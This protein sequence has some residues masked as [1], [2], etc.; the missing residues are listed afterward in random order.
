VAKGGI[1][2]QINIIW[3]SILILSC[4]VLG[5]LDE[6][7]ETYWDIPTIEGSGHISVEPFR[8]DNNLDIFNRATE[9]NWPGNGTA[10]NPYIIEDY[11][12][13]GEGYGYCIYIGNT[14][15][16][17]ILKDC[18]LHSAS[19]HSNIP[20][21]K[22]SGLMLHDVKNATIINNTVSDNNYGIYIYSSAVYISNCKIVENV[23]GLYDEGDALSQVINTFASGR[24]METATIINGG[25]HD[26]YSIRIPKMAI[27]KSASIE[28]EGIE[29]KNEA[30]IKDSFWQNSPAMYGDWLVWQDNRDGDREI[31][32]Y[33]LSVDSDYNGVP[34]YLETPRLESDPALVRITN[35][36]NLQLTPDICGDII[37]WSDFR[38]GVL[39]IYA[40]TFSNN[41]EWPVVVN[42]AS[43]WM[44]DVDGD[45]IVWSDK[46]N[47]N[48]DIY[49]FNISTGETSRLSTSER[50]DFSPQIHNDKIV[51]YSYE[52]S[53]GRDE[54]SDICLF[55]IKEWKFIEVTNDDPIQYSPSIY[56]DNIV[57]HDNT[58]GNWEIFL[59]NITTS[60][61]QRITREKEQSFAPHMYEDKMVYYFHDRV[62]DIWSVRMYDMNTSAQ[63]DIESET[64][65]DSNP[66]IYGNRIA[67]LNKTDAKNDIYVL[68]FSIAGNPHDVTVDLGCDG[69]REF[70]RIG[71]LDC[72]ERLNSST[73]LNE[74]ESLLPGVGRG[75]LDIPINISFDKSGRVKLRSLN[76]TYYLPSIIINTSL[77]NNTNSG[78]YCRGSTS[79]FI[80][81][82]FNGN[83]IDVTVSSNGN[84]RLL[85]CTFSDSKLSFLSRESNLTV[86]NY[87]NV[88]VQNFS[89]EPINA[90]VIVEDNGQLIFDDYLGVDG[91]VQLIVVTDASHNLSGKNNNDTYV[92]IS[93]GSQEFYD[94]P[95]DVDMGI[96]HWEVFE[97]GILNIN[98][99]VGWNLISIP[100]K[101]SNHTIERV[102]DSISGSYDTVQVYNSSDVDSWKSYNVIRPIN[103]N[104]LGE[105]NRKLSFWIHITDNCTLRLSGGI[106]DTTAIQLYTGWNLVGY[107]TMTNNIP[108][109]NA[110]SGT[111]ADKVIGFDHGSPY[112]LKELSPNYL[113]RPGEGYWVHVPAN[114]IWIVD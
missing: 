21:Y 92:T 34:N 41:T 74:L 51:W 2:R 36:P 32:A 65:G 33:N 22:D 68:D 113:M 25:N 111:G 103:L 14:T 44:P 49:L 95:R 67:W 42:P 112:L 54:Y 66:V 59:Y 58:Y 17:F 89:K 63:I 15:N 81:S 24:E 62:H 40:Y 23:Y 7:E 61:K 19:G 109:I 30:I 35:N 80:N 3:L 10:E 9:W 102:L 97:S 60:S 100:Y 38:N 12:I 11:D 93:L 69:D 70:E 26:D 16:Y 1:M 94:N 20:F 107:P 83:P 50:K 104:D 47:G 52:G 64:N 13:N 53:P 88:K 29:I 77:M 6:R 82:T 114:I 56:E 91:L 71:M 98:L 84:P 55:D 86:Q 106:D 90:R 85:N 76:I 8:I 79:R 96:S 73:L 43:Q 46:R 57:W 45:H 75:Y 110:L 72:I 37:V 108:I 27:I 48:Y 5:A 39:D 4:S 78:A 87:L 99:S 31:Y 18:S 105:L 28:V 101:L